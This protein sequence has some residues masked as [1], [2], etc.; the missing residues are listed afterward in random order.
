MHFEGHAQRVTVYVGSS[1][2][3]NG[4]NLAAAIVSR[5]R[6][7]GIAGATASLGI[8][9]FGR[10]SRIHRAHL[11]GLSEDLPERIEIIDQP[12][13]INALLPALEEMVAGGLIIV[14][15]VYV[16]RDTHDSRPARSG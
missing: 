16:V 8:M 7:L 6:E 4:R 13:R 10:T 1:D 5:C 2:T 9:G 14:E 12:D 3:W 11:F 15:D